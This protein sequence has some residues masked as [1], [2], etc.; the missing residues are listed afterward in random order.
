MSVH[1]AGLSKYKALVRG[2]NALHFLPFSLNTAHRVR[3]LGQ[4]AEKINQTQNTRRTHLLEVWLA[5]AIPVSA[6]RVD[7]SHP[8]TRHR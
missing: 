8:A 2:V 7:T 4:P 6:P 3:R 5:P 1:S